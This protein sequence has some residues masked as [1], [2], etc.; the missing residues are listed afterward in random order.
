MYME[1]QKAQHAVIYCKT[2]QR[3]GA[4]LIHWLFFLLCLF[5]LLLL[6]LLLV[7]IDKVKPRE[8][9][10]EQQRLFLTSRLPVETERE[11]HGE[12]KD[13]PHCCFIL[14]RF[15]YQAR[16]ASGPFHFVNFSNKLKRKGIL[17]R[18][19]SCID[20]LSTSEEFLDVNNVAVYTITTHRSL[21]CISLIHSLVIGNETPITKMATCILV[22]EILPCLNN[23][24]L[25]P[26]LQ[27]NK[28]KN[29]S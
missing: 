24:Y 6:L 27:K 16:R 8:L 15:Y 19:V 29:T 11:T 20:E 1:A 14:S 7:L 21:P 13:K 9:E 5:I 12:G 17:K 3:V 22:A 25:A 4:Y 10:Q 23:I 28:N 2:W 18:I 26:T